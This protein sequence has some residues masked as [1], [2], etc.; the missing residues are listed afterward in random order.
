[1]RRGGDDH[2]VVDPVTV[3]LHIG[4]L[5]HRRVH[6]A[7]RRKTEKS[8]VADLPHQKSDLV[9]MRVDQNFHPVFSTRPAH[10]HQVAHWVDPDL[11]KVFPKHGRPGKLLRRPPRK[12]GHRHHTAQLKNKRLG[13]LWQPVLRRISCFLH[14][15]LQRKTL[16]VLPS[17]FCPDCDTGSL[18]QYVLPRSRRHDPD[19]LWCV[20]P[21]GS[22]RS[23]VRT[24]PFFR[25]Q[26]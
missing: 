16:S 20:P 12:A 24:F 9:K 15:D 13:I 14:K 6:P 23:P 3:Y 11:V 21:A 19:R 22:G 26:T 1:M 25:R 5:K 2:T 4:R 8:A 7:D 17:I 10:K 18:P